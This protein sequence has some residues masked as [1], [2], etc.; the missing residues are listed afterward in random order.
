MASAPRSRAAPTASVSPANRVT[1]WSA[2]SAA[3]PL[4]SAGAP[5]ARA[6]SATSLTA[7][8]AARTSVRMAPEASV[9]FSSGSGGSWGGTLIVVTGPP[10]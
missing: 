6:H 8:A 3:S 4:K 7:V 5:L 10:P 1:A 9:T 2:A